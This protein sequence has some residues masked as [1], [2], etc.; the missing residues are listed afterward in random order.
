MLLAST[1]PARATGIVPFGQ[2]ITFGADPG[3]EMRIAWQVPMPVADPFVR[4]GTSPFDLGERIDLMVVDIAT[5]SMGSTT[6]A[7]RTLNG[8]GIEI[9]RFTLVR[10]A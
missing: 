4:I 2:H 9:D 8:S 5:P 1:T 6:M 10:S 3:S 7:V